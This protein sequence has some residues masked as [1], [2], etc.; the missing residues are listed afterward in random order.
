M[1]PPSGVV[2]AS[3]GGVKLC[4]LVDEWCRM[5]WEMNR[6]TGASYS[7]MR[8]LIR[9]VMV[10]KEPSRMAKLLTCLS[11]NPHLWSWDVDYDQRLAEWASCTGWPG[12]ALET[13]R[14]SVIRGELRV[15]S[16]LLC[17]EWSQLRRF[18]SLGCPLGYGKKIDL[19]LC[20]IKFVYA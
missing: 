16:L 14:S 9:S 2:S 7:V 4:H 13:V 5:E 20:V 3:N 12:S 19:S 17:I 1:P 6:R 10:K 15:E 8:V 18:I 11:F